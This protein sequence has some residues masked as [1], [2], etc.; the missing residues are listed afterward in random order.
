MKTQ[1]I[2]DAVSGSDASGW[3]QE[4]GSLNL[5]VGAIHSL[6]TN[7]SELW[8]SRLW[9]CSTIYASELGLGG[10]AKFR[11]LYQ[12]LLMGKIGVFITVLV[13]KLWYEHTQEYLSP[14]VSARIKAPLISFISAIHRIFL[15][16]SIKFEKWCEPVL[17]IIV[18]TSIDTSCANI[19]QKQH[20]AIVAT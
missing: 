20:I 9:Y 17:F 12:K 13:S 5:K 6:D 14:T 8:C 19:F 3:R 2:W 7:S 16:C 1:F 11:A 4:T 10:G 18:T 15:S